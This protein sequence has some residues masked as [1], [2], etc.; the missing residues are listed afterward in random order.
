MP[1]HLAPLL[2]GLVSITLV[3]QT[4]LPPT[5]TPT[6]E[7]T[8]NLKGCADLG[9]TTVNAADP[10]GWGYTMPSPDG[11]YVVQGQ[12]LGSH[13]CHNI[14]IYQCV[15]Q[16]S[17][18]EI[19]CDG[20]FPPES[21][22]LVF[23]TNWV[24]NDDLLI[25]RLNKPQTLH[26]PDYFKVDL[27][28]AKGM[29]KVVS[30][31]PDGQWQIFSSGRDKM[32]ELYRQRLD[33]SHVQRLTY[34]RGLGNFYGWSPDGKWMIFDYDDAHRYGLLPVRMHL[35]GSELQPLMT[36]ND[37]G[38]SDSS[39]WYTL[40]FSPDSRWLLMQA[41]GASSSGSVPVIYR[42]GVPDGG[43]MRLTDPNV[44]YKFVDWSPDGRALVWHWNAN[45]RGLAFELVDVATMK[46][47]LLVAGDA[48][49]FQR[50][51]GDHKAALFLTHNAQGNA[52]WNRAE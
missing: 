20:V 25:T 34:S 45:T 9:I 41:Y 32:S 2:L 27:S 29:D 39:I 24:S 40:A 46:Y 49:E 47:S 7:Q 37:L 21:Q 33:G 18:G 43:L 12:H 19:G 5:P 4:S 38:Y 17:S 14:N 26:M 11:T 51:T 31:S 16:Q 42:L 8:A 50:W 52:V 15:T 44:A 10:Y 28:P 36:D 22:D 30:L 1:K 48:L 6:A 13:G 3:A 23:A 35:D